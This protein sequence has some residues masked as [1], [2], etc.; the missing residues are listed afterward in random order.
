[1]GVL[2]AQDRSLTF[3]DMALIRGTCLTGYAE[4]V[5]E[6][7]GDPER[8]LHAAG[9][10]VPDIGRNDVFVSYPGVIHAVESAAVAVG[11]ADFGRR[12]AARQSIEILGP[13]GSAAKTSA[14]VADALAIFERYIAAYS[15]AI[16]T[17]LRPQPGSTRLI[18][19]LR[20]VLDKV[21][22]H[23]QVTELSLGVALG[24]CRF[25]VGRDYAPVKV[26]I[27]HEHLSPRAE[28]VSYFGCA[29]HFNDRLAGFTIDAATLKRPLQ[30]DDVTHQAL[31]DYLRS[32]RATQEPGLAGAIRDLVRQL[33]PTGAVTL[34]VIAAQFSLHPKTMQRRLASEGHTYGSLVD[35]VRKES[36]ER[37]LRETEL[38]LT[39]LARE[40]GYSEQSA[41]TRSCHRWFGDSPANI[42][43]RARTGLPAAP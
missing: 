23:P 38:S 36:A 13:V 15:P 26:H 25:L 39:H 33:L 2:T 11:V 42:R 17:T 3:A 9:L 34:D 35:H 24:V 41:L 1:M 5:A 29:P 4:L 6:L 18:F 22:A 7:G 19:E 14:T 43:R 40:L 28:Y 27:P 16:R 37:Y 21:V 8:H 10:R 20:I 12:L 30:R 31:L 32:V